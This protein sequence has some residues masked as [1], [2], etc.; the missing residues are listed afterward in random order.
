[1]SVV[2]FDPLGFLLIPLGFVLAIGYAKTER[3]YAIAFLLAIVTYSVGLFLSI[4]A[5]GLSINKTLGFLVFS[6]VLLWGIASLLPV[7]EPVQVKRK[8]KT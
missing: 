2:G 6:A 4:T 5:F 3:V 1:M 8:G 7:Q